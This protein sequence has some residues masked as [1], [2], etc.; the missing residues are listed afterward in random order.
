MESP[1]ENHTRIEYI[2]SVASSPQAERLGKFCKE[3]GI[4]LALVTESFFQAFASEHFKPSA[5][6]KS[7]CG[8]EWLANGLITMRETYEFL[9]AYIRIHRLAKGPIILLNDR[10][11]ELFMEERDHIL[12]GELITLLPCALLLQKSPEQAV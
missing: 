8:N 5:T 6:L 10:L 12:A 4:H 9:H 3:E 2:A 7:M 11:K 1:D